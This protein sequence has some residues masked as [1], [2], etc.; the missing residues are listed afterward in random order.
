MEVTLVSGDLSGHA[1]VSRCI[2]AQGQQGHQELSPS[3]GHRVQGTVLT[4]RPRTRTAP[5]VLA[6]Q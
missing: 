4:L 3:G 1:V 6:K 5:K 2:T